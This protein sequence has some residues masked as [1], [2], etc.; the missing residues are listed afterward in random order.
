MRFLTNYKYPALVLAALAALPVAKLIAAEEQ[1]QPSQPDYKL[2]NVKAD[3]LKRNWGQKKT[4]LLTGNVVITQG[5]TVLKS[6]KIEYDEESQIA[7]SPG[8]LTI[9]DPEADISGASGVAYL[10]E[11]RGLV[12]GAVKLVVKPKRKDTSDGKPSEWKDPA[13][14]TCD[15]L[16]YLYKVKQATA[17]G[18]LKMLQKD[19]TVT[20]EK[21]VFMVKQELMTL[22]GD[23]KGS[24]EKGQTVSAGG[25]V[26][27]SLKEGD[28]WMEIEQATGTFKVKSEEEEPEKASPA[29][30]PAPE[31]RK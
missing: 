22:T 26:T 2:V 21:A 31:V 16:E 3:V 1:K 30:A 14:I 11:R 18:H 23:V 12:E 24:D 28:E 9:S 13:T 20:A 7:K 10:K 19:R 15:T 6:D 17:A 27:V 4:V 5:D 8:P 25:K 29:P